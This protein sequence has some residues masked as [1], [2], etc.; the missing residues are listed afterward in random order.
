[1]KHMY[2]AVAYSVVV[3]VPR[4]DPQFVVVH[5]GRDHL[6]E[7]S[8]PVLLA[9]ELHQS[10]VDVCTAGQEE[11]APRTD[12]MEEKQVV[13]F[14]ELTVVPLGRLFLEI[15]P[16][17]QLLGVWEGDAVHPLQGLSLA[18]SLPVCG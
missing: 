15:L 3:P 17:L 11:T 7:A 2:V 14:A 16:L 8:L 13:L 1:M 9:N 4:G 10:V 18:V 5:V 6:L 12:F